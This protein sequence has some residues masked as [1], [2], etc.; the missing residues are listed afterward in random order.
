M[1]VLLCR[2]V[3][4]HELTVLEKVRHPNIVQFIGAVTQNIPMMIVL[5]YHSKVIILLSLHCFP[6]NL[7]FWLLTILRHF[8]HWPSYDGLVRLFVLKC[9]LLLQT[10]QGDLA[11]YLQK[12]GRISTSKALRF[13]L[14]IARYSH[15]CSFFIPYSLHSG[16]WD[17]A[18]YAGEWIVFTSA[19]PN[20]SYTAI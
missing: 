19:S 7:L 17:D 12:K 18:F 2:N 16:L 15:F 10:F 6:A 3:F 5:E 8:V 1:C 14:E 13:A 4:R 20:Q 11:S 9:L